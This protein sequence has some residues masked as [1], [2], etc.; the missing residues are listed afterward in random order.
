MKLLLSKEDGVDS[1]SPVINCPLCLSEVPFTRKPESRSSTVYGYGLDFRI[2]PRDCNL[3]VELA[4]CPN[5]L[6]TSRVEDFRRRVPGH[7]QELIR[8]R[9]YVKMFRSSDA[10]ASSARSWLAHISILEARGL[11]P[12]DL[13][14]ISLKGSWVARELH[15]LATEFE[16]LRAAD[17]FL[18]DAL[19]RGLTKG[20]PGMVMY[21]LGEINRRRGEYLRAREML[22][23]LGNNPRYRY[24]ALLLTVLVE[25]EDS[26]PYWSRHAPDQ[27]E[28]HSS[29]FKGLFP[30]LRSIPP[31]KTEFFPDELSEPS[32]QPD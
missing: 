29:R 20:D 4:T 12:R 31:G 30:S 11:N 8:S 27:M 22:T 18:D 10:E 23:F 28:Q 25:E 19:R 14:V 1:S 26:T 15:S 32:E 5:C 2:V 21:L 13:A 7:V 16:L 24:P 6:F 3:S 9:E 17:G